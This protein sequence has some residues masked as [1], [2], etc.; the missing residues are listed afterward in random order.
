MNWLKEGGLKSQ[1]P[2]KIP[3]ML[4]ALEWGG[5]RGRGKA[6]HPE[7]IMGKSAQWI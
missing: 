3:R 1:N 7:T 5:G 2:F 4:L 6:R